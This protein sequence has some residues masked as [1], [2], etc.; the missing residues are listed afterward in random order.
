MKKRLYD[1]IKSVFGDF[2]KRT[3][4]TSAF[5]FTASLIFAGYNI[6]LGAA[7]KTAWNI[8]IAAY[9]ALLTG[10][11]AYVGVH[12]IKWNK[13]GLSEEEKNG[14]RKKLFLLQSIFLFIIDFA[15]I[16]PISL[17]V[18]QRKN[19]EYSKIPAIAIAAYTVYKI[20]FSTKS[21]VK[22][23]QTPH[24]SVK[25][26]RTLNF[27][28]ALVSVLSL[29]YTLIMTFGDGVNGDML[30]LTATS[31]F[32]IWAF[33]FAVSVTTLVRAIRAIKTTPPQ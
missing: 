21:F 7:Y 20:V 26:L 3:F 30:T 11:R 17:M 2:E 9:Y 16:A 13:S 29:Q 19:V 23:K 14:K 32:V 24:P 1:S 33:L 31:S 25:I 4:F 10:L 5:S 22:T 15:L 6:F 18:L 27:I 28:D 8:G 12:E